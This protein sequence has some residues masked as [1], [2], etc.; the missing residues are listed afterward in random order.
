MA[1]LLWGLVPS[2]QLGEKWAKAGGRARRVVVFV[3]EIE[4][5]A[6]PLVVVGALGGRDAGLFQA[7]LEGYRGFV[8][9]L[10]HSNGCG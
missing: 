6:D 5:E 3:A 2:G 4:V 7:A 1:S 9:N 8:G 10:L